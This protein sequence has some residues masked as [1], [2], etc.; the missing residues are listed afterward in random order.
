MRLKGEQHGAEITSEIFHKE[1]DR[2]VF[3][4]RYLSEASIKKRG[5]RAFFYN[6][7]I[8]LKKLS[9]LGWKD[10]RTSDR[11]GYGMEKIPLSQI[12]PDLPPCV[13]P[14]VKHLFVF[15]A[16]GDNRVFVGIQLG[17]I[18]RVLFIEAHF[19]DIYRHD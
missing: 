1:E 16:T 5:D 2:P 4:F 15:R 19:G 6:F 12:L 9:E 18:F 7:L 10:I 13:T 8:R 3:C 17:N 11:H 14:D